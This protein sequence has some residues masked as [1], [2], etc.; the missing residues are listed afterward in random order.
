MTSI[1]SLLK[2][3]DNVLDELARKRYVDLTAPSWINLQYQEPRFYTPLD[4]FRNMLTQKDDEFF[5]IPP[6]VKKEYRTP[7]TAITL[8]I[9]IGNSKPLSVN[10]IASIR[11]LV[12]WEVYADIIEE[13]NPHKDAANISFADYFQMRGDNKTAQAIRN[14]GCQNITSLEDLVDVLKKEK[15]KEE[16]LP[17]LI[18]VAGYFYDDTLVIY[19]FKDEAGPKRRLMQAVKKSL[20]EEELEEFAVRD[21]GLSVNNRA[22]YVLKHFLD[23]G[24]LHPS[25]FL[26]KQ[27][28]YEWPKLIKEHSL[29]AVARHAWSTDSLAK[30]PFQDIHDYVEY[31]KAGY[32]YRDFISYLPL[33]TSKGNDLLAEA[34]QWLTFPI[35]L[36]SFNPFDNEV[37][38][39]N[40]GFF[41]NIRYENRWRKKGKIIGFTSAPWTNEK[42]AE[43][44]SMQAA[45]L[46]GVP[47][48]ASYTTKPHKEGSLRLIESSWQPPCEEPDEY[49]RQELKMLEQAKRF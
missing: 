46:V 11:P 44:V 48:R 40:Y 26:S 30:I 22:K 2:N 43:W 27:E 16:F 31:L 39:T 3:E 4:D 10:F 35:V 37:K 15:N 19:P 18:G 33:T 32:E 17:H 23:N 34:P 20:K 45:D 41:S 29:D 14:G 49:E 6:H 25:R 47:V 1:G 9:P 24:V 12:N 8:P 13:E 7:I 21:S 28:Q 5:Y 38:V 42:F 36:T